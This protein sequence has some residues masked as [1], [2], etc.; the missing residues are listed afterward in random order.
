M[1]FYQHKIRTSLLWSV[2]CEKY[3]CSHWQ[4]S[5]ARIF[6]KY[7]RILSALA[8]KAASIK[9]SS[10]WFASGTS[11][12]N[13][14]WHSG[15][16][17]VSYSRLETATTRLVSGHRGIVNVLVRIPQ[18]INCSVSCKYQRPCGQKSILSRKSFYDLLYIHCIIHQR[19]NCAD[20]EML[21][22]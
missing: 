4:I 16:L 21:H 1:L 11:L 18:G 3:L 19:G 17:N 14:G 22:M 7:C 20:Y 2:M 5:A 6:R 10:L 8:I 13:R 15:T 9:D 12:V